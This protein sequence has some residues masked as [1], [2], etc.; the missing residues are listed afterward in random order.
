MSY[1]VFILGLIFTG[2]ISFGHAQSGGVE[3]EKD[4]LIALLQEYRATY[5]IHP[6]VP[7]IVSLGTRTVEKKTGTRGKTRGFRVQIY[8]GASRSEANSVQARFQNSY[9]DVSAY[10]T[11]DEPNYR[12]KVG[13]FRS[14][15]EATNLMRELRSAY[16][17]VFVFTEDIWVYE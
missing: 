10:L 3:V 2:A 15:G 5:S 12:V 9:S 16:N 13:D 8:S 4:A 7:K 1:K 11:Y 6:A 14:R 17:N